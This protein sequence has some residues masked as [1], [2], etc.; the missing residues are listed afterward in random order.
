LAKPNITWA[1]DADE[2]D[3]QDAYDFLCGLTQDDGSARGIVTALRSAKAK[4]MK[5]KNIIRANAT[6]YEGKAARKQRMQQAKDGVPFNPILLVR[7]DLMNSG[8]RLLIADGFS[9]THAA[10]KCDPEATV[11]AKMV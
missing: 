1:A 2:S 4:P 10:L 7:G 8:R 9:R 11:M 3:Y 6:R 5:A